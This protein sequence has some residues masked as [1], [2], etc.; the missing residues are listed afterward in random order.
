MRLASLVVGVLVTLAIGIYGGMTIEADQI[1]VHWNAAGEP[2]RYDDKWFGFMVI[3]IA[4]LITVTLI[5]LLPKMNTRKST[6]DVTLNNPM[7]ATSAIAVTWLMV[8]VQLFMY[9]AATGAEFDIA[10]WITT[11]VSI[12]LIVMGNVL[13]K[14]RPNQFVGIRT[15]WTL[16]SDEVWFH[17]HRIGGPLFILA[18]VITI[19]ATL[20]APKIALYVLIGMAIVVALFSVIYSWYKF[21]QLSQT[22]S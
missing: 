15:P 10:Y 8:M 20:V 2:D 19:V 4:S 6:A 9:V 18:G 17:T 7:V 14:I 5:L 11:L 21:N 3:P 12:L 13:T 16:D 1:A 22:N